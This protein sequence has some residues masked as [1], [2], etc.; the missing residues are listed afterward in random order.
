MYSIISAQ[1]SLLLLDYQII[2]KN[3]SIVLAWSSSHQIDLHYLSTISHKISLLL[4]RMV[5]GT[6]GSFQE[7]RAKHI[8]PSISH[9][10]AILCDNWELVGLVYH[11]KNGGYYKVPSMTDVRCSYYTKKMEV[12]ME[13]GTCFFTKCN[14][15][16][17][18]IFTKLFQ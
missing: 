15:M 18:C 10:Q 4:P 9:P 5:I 2:L 8:Q 12:G 3:I 11:N 14:L 13:G 17:T 16:L 7:P 1:Q 6:T